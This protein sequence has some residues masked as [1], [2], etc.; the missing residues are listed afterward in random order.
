M[1]GSGALGR[2]S[3]YSVIGGSKPYFRPTYYPSAYELLQLHR[4]HLQI[5][6]NFAVRDKVI[7]NKFPGCSFANGIFKLGP[8][9]REN[10]HMKELMELIRKRS[11]LMTR[12]NNQR[13]INN[14]IFHSASK[15]LTAEQ[16][17]KR[18]SFQTPDS[19]VYF[20]PQLYTAANTWPNYWQ[21]P[22]QKHVIPRPRWSR[23]PE[24][25]NI[26][27]VQEPLTYPLALDY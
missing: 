9:K 10:Y 17:K 15:I 16:L 26:T 7:D 11:I 22:T 8:R 14:R 4:T 12:I 5:L 25:D 3:F 19:N 6:N 18:F 2:G 13:A 24:F 27:R 20:N 23:V 21:H 1:S